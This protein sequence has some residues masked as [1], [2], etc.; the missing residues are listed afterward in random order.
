MPPAEESPGRLELRTAVF[1]DD[2]T[3]VWT[4]GGNGQTALA[5]ELATGRPVGAPL[6]DVPAW[7]SSRLAQSPDGRRVATVLDAS[8]APGLTDLVQVWEAGTGR[9]VGP[10]LAHPNF[11]LAMAF[12]PDGRRLACG[13][14]FHAVFVWDVETGRLMGPPLPQGGIFTDVAFA[15]DGQ[16]LAV[17]TWAHKARL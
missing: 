12:S 10:P 16:S 3:R 5:W 4:A 1:S 6:P 8:F 11:V 14:H 17:A 13:G 9:P 15:A 2:R 7:G